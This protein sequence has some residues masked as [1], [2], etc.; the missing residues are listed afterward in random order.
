MSRT[1]LPFAAWAAVAAGA[2][3]IGLTAVAAVRGV[4]ADTPVRVLS[5]AD[6]ARILADPGEELDPMPI[7]TSAQ[8][9][10]AADAA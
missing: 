10:A 3:A 1:W 2:A 9:D 8:V 7:L 4:V 5:A 6:V